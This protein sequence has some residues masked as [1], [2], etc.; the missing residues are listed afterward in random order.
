MANEMRRSDT[1]HVGGCI[2]VDGNVGMF[3]ASLPGKKCL[4][5]FLKVFPDLILLLRNY[6]STLTEGNYLLVKGNDLSH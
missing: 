6:S 4:R 3:E 5:K 1:K 2:L